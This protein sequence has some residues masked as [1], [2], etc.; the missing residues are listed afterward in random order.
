MAL[1]FPI[2][3]TNGQTYQSGSSPIYTFNGRVWELSSA[4]TGIAALNSFTASLQQALQLTGSNATMLGNLNVQGT[5]TALNQASL[6]ITDKFIRVAS[7]S[8]SSAQS[9]GA[10]LI[11][12]GANVTMSWDSSNSQITFNTQ[13]SAS[14]FIGDGS[15]LTG[16]T[17]YTNSD[18]LN[19]LNSKGVISG[20]AQIIG[21]LNPLNSYTSSN[22]TK[23]A[24]IQ[25]I[26]ASLISATGSYE[27]KGRGIISGSSQLTS[28]YDT[29]YTLSGS[30]SATP[31]GT[32]SSSAQ[33]PSGIVSSSSQI[34][35]SL[36]LRYQL[37]GSVGSGTISAGTVSSSTQIAT[38]GFITASTF[39]TYTASTDLVNATQSLRITSLETTS[40]SV[41]L[42]N[43]TQSVRL[44]NLENLT[45]SLATTGSNSFNGNQIVTGSLT[46]SSVATISASIAANASALTLSSGSNLYIQNNGVAEISGSLRVSG[47]LALT[48]SISI[49]SGSITMSNRPA[50]RVTGAGGLTTATTVLSG[51]MVVVDYN[52]G[53]YYNTS[54]GTFTAPIAGLYQVNLVV[55]TYSNS[56]VASQAVIVK[57]NTS[58]NNG[59]VQG[60]IEWGANTSMNHTGVST[61]SKLA[62]GDTLKAMIFMGSASFD[63]NDNFS[64]AYIG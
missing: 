2:S 42:I 15:S 8:V 41:I 36:D 4:N 52:E 27:T 18:N 38:L 53:G 16:V 35:S 20:S 50:F 51:S 17:S 31:A 26:T 33:L 25:N 24:T 12:D 3:P 9:N 13:I 46:V 40:A 56:G 39:T 43:T 29:R 60:M 54:N 57:N 11:I 47:S 62:V 34:T 1:V 7:G 6:Q 49:S 22:D 37:S 10:G 19:Y 5:Q 58:G 48:G 14:K 30:I 44:G 45:G 28:S 21:I 32:I 61:I 55:R 64:V 23:W 59:S 63:G